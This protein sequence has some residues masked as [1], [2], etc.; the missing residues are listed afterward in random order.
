MAYLNVRDRVIEAKIAYVGSLAT[1]PASTFAALERIHGSDAL[2]SGDALSL[3]VVRP[4]DAVNDCT[5][6]LKLV[7][8]HECSSAST[9]A[10][11][12]DDVDGVVVVVG[13]DTSSAQPFDALRAALAARAVPVVVQIDG[14]IEAGVAADEVARRL[15]IDQWPHVVASAASGVGVQETLNRVVEDVMQSMTGSE[16]SDREMRPSVDVPRGEGNPLLSALRKVLES[17]VEAHVAKLGDELLARVEKTVDARLAELSARIDKTV[18]AQA[19]LLA[20]TKKAAT[21]DDLDTAA[22]GFRDRVESTERLVVAVNERVSAME[23]GTEVLHRQLSSSTDELLKSARHACTR[24]DL[25][26]CA[27]DIRRELAHVVEASSTAI[28]SATAVLRRNIEAV[29]VD[30]KK[31]GATGA[32]SELGA[33]LDALDAQAKTIAKSVEA[34]TAVTRE[35]KAADEAVARD[36]RE[37]VVRRIS[38][39]DQAV[40][41]VTA[42]T[43]G[44]SALTVE[45]SARIEGRIVELIEELKKPKK[46]WFG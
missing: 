28:T 21:K 29:S 26:T 40:R 44:V 41:E 35:L 4:T 33:K 36:I 43:G 18:A 2:T 1:E 38:A 27:T 14:D 8:T 22:N 39:L 34:S 15:E 30:V 7:G 32:V 5:L 16:P 37:S 19:E 25:A 31:N 20:A 46:G 24:E 17:T 23:A 10:G 6:R 3:D 12:L 9:L 11:V 42:Q 13:K 45:S